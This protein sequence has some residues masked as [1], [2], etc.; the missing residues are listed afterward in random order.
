MDAEN[1]W[2]KNYM[3]LDEWMET[4]VSNLS[5]RLLHSIKKFASSQ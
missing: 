4:D 3:K 5:F 1:L 2:E